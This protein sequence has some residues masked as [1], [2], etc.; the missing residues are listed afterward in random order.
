MFRLVAT[1]FIGVRAY[2][3]ECFHWRML[4]P[5]RASKGVNDKTRPYDS[6]ISCGMGRGSDARYTSWT[7]NSPKVECDRQT[8]G[9]TNQQS[10]RT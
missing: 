3:G 4:P 1:L 8:E 9:L 5:E 7:E 10:A 6:S 2:I